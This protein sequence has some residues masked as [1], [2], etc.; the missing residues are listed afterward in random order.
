MAGRTVLV[1]GGHR[2]HR[3]G[4]RPGPGRTRRPGRDHRPGP[5]ARRRRRARDRGCRRCPGGGLRRGPVVAGRGQ[6][7]GRRGAPAPGP[8]RRARQQRRRVLEHPAPHRRR[9]RAHLCAEPP[10]AVPAHQPA[11]PPA[12][13]GHLRP[14]GD[15]GVPRARHR[16]DRLRRPPGRT[17]LLGCAR[18]Q[19]V[20]ARQRPVHLRVGEEA[21]GHRGHRQRPASRCGEHVVRRRGSRPGPAT[22]GPAAAAVHAIARAGRRHVDPPGLCSRSRAGDGPLLRQVHPAEVLRAQLRRVGRGEAVAGQRRPGPG[23]AS[24]PP[25]SNERTREW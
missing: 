22:G 15:G 21:A 19:P 24:G 20:Q 11:A 25:D 3:E 18:L 2:G 5:A 23:P 10:R 14:R 6:T 7:A 13:T 8:D 1:T 9:T 16:T 17:V 4:D 12:R